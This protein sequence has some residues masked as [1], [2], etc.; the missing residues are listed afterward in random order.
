MKIGALAATVA[1]GVLMTSS[2]MAAP[3]LINGGFEDLGGA[4]PQGW[5]GYTFG[6]GYSPV[7][8]GWSTDPLSMDQPGSTGE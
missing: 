8:P 4:S 6:A 5:G 7:L 2:A 3:L 1:A